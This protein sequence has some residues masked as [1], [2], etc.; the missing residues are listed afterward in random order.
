MQQE[1]LI[2]L[3]NSGDVSALVELAKVTFRDAYQLL[4]DPADIADYV[5][6]HFT[7]QN[8]T[9]ILN[10]PL[11]TLFVV[12]GGLRYV[13]YAHVRRS[14]VPSCVV[15]PTPI[16]LV[17]LYLQQTEIGKGLGSRL[18]NT[19]QNEARRVQCRTIW[20]SV[21]DKNVRAVEFYKRFGFIDVGTKEFYFGGR[22]YHDPVM[23]MTLPE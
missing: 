6:K 23:A 17:R 14:P 18:M 7:P 4:D 5:A 2:R 22:I 19:V 15:G 3:A 13:G 10:D 1:P 16:E 21:Y 20:L 8:F 9:S 12:M 11:S